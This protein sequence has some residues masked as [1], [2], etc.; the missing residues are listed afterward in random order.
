M[1]KVITCGA[2]NP[3]NKGLRMDNDDDGVTVN[4]LDIIDD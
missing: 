3:I 2:D 4:K 1:T